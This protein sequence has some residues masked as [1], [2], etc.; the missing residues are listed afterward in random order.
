MAHWIKILQ[1][2]FTVY[3]DYGKN[4]KR[5]SEQMVFNGVAIISAILVATG[6]VPLGLENSEIM[7][8]GTGIY[9]AIVM[10]IRLR[11]K[12]GR[13]KVLDDIASKDSKP[14]EPKPWDHH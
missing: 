3:S 6:V 9:A 5:I 1:D 10:A 2:M 8:L 7:G 13:I 14:D 12:G 4:G 11:S